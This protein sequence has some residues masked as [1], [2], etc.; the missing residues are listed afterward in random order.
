M[1]REGCWIVALI[2]KMWVT[3]CSSSQRVE[4]QEYLSVFRA[5]SSRES[6]NGQTK[7]S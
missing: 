2:N 1:S 3:C 4:D 6:C 5:A 7:W